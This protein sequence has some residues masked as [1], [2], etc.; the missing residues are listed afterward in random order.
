[1]QRSLASNRTKEAISGMRKEKTT[2][3]F[4]STIFNLYF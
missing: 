1:M 3:P 2:A 4:L